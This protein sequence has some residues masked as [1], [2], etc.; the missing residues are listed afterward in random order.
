MKFLVS[1]NSGREKTRK[2]KNFFS[3]FMVLSFSSM[4]RVYG[5]C[6]REREMCRM[7]P[8]IVSLVVE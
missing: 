7:Q 4:T 6:V 1:E 5:K 3:S 2:E 8:L